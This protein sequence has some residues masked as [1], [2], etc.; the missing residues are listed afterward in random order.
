MKKDNKYCLVTL[1]YSLLGKD[2]KG[3][4]K[5]LDEKTEKIIITGKKEEVLNK[6]RHAEDSLTG[7]GHSFSFHLPRYLKR[8][9][10]LWKNSYYR[11]LKI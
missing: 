3:K 11:L 9:A 2:K 4:S 7:N 10:E 5:L 8:H 1:K 6:I